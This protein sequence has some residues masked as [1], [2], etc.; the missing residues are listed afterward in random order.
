MILS[1]EYSFLCCNTIWGVTWQQTA[2][3]AAT[4]ICYIFFSMRQ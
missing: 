3:T 4:I 1:P 2:D